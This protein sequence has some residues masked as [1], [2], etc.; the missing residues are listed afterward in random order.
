MGY[1][2]DSD[3]IQRTKASYGDQAATLVGIDAIYQLFRSA[4]DIDFASYKD[5]TVLRAIHR[6]LAMKQCESVDQYVALPKAE[7][8][9]RTPCMATC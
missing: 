2:N 6:R 5:S 1:A 8:P 3:H 9:N 4:Y 7:P